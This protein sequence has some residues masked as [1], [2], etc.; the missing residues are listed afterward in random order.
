[1][2]E[3]EKMSD[4]FER[5]YIEVTN[6]CNFKCQFCPYSV[7]KRRRGHMGLD[8]LEKILDEISSFY[9]RPYILFHL[10]G[11][12]LVYP[13]I[14]DAISMAIERGL[15]L[16]L[17]TN[18]STFH[19][20]PKHIHQ[21]VES[22]VSKVTISL[23]T[24]D[25]ETFALRG[26]PKGLGAE[27]YFQGI[28]Q[29]VR[30]NTQ[31]ESMTAVQ[32]KFM[33]STPSFFSMPYKM[34]SVIDGRKQL[35]DHFGHWT[36]RILKGIM[37]DSD[38]K[39]FINKRFNYLF[40]GIPQSFSIDPKVVL[41]SFPLENWGNLNQKKVYSAR[42]G[43]CDAATAQL[44]ILH[45]GTVVP[46]CTDFE[47]LIPLGNV[48]EQSLSQILLGQS[49]RDLRSAFKRL[50]VHHPLCRKCLGANTRGKSIV[51]QLGSI[52]YYKMIKP[53]IYNTSRGRY[54]VL[55]PNLVSDS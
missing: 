39:K 45:E 8:L 24:P 35:R 40:P 16:E 46:C 17:I 32:I 6:V 2:S 25:I 55:A 5:I 19:L 36:E 31:S 48:N 3:A 1:M 51:R 37:S 52:A 23:Q 41:C 20:V 53:C 27:Q 44:G 13:H 42:I 4:R 9:R 22:G 33:D 15:N 50:Q 18:G 30:E 34:L 7:M 14:F 28:T 26:A 12:P 29:F 43:C 38:L 54:E 49:R 47:G 11:E 10:M 21:L